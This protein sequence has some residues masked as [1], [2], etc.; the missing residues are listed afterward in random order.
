MTSI[1]HDATIFLFSKSFYL[2]RGEGADSKLRRITG[3][4]V[5]ISRVLHSQT[6]IQRAN[7]YYYAA[8]QGH[9]WCE[10]AEI[11]SGSQ[12]NFQVLPTQDDGN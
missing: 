4:Y 10:F 1:L 5:D 3:K 6:K 9:G 2:Y 12:E 7:E 11:A 8:A